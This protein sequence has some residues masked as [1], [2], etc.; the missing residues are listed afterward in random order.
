ML[1]IN[2]IKQT[3]QGYA[4]YSKE[5]KRLSRYYGSKQ[6]AAQRLAEIE[7]FASNEE[8]KPTRKERDPA[9]TAGIRRSAKAEI[10]KRLAE[11]EQ[12]IL[13]LIE[14]LPVRSI[15]INKTRYEFEVD[16][17]RFEQIS[18]EIKAIINRWLQ[19]AQPNKPIRWF[20]DSHLNQSYRNGTVEA[21]TRLQALVEAVSGE[22]VGD[23][24]SVERVLNSEPYR[25][26]IE[27]VFARVFEE[28]AGFADEAG[29]N[30]AR[31][32]AQ[33]MAAGNSPRSIAS[34][35]RKEF[36]GLKGYRALR[37]ARTEINKAH[38]DARM[39]QAKD[40]RDRVGV[41]TMI[42]HISALVPNTRATHASRHGKL[43]TIEE[44]QAWW[45]EGY[46]RINCLCSTLEIIFIDGEPIQQ[47][48]IERMRK[49]GQQYFAAN[50][51]KAA[52]VGI[53]A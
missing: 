3:K 51:K 33:G 46:N 38:T 9:G 53:T 32:L 34:A 6:E 52:K 21:A 47:D 45:S 18:E 49:R 29:T 8:V 12:E 42:M 20:F 31:V 1:A 48:L 23:A 30:L 15:T 36:R 27:L 19:T 4:V 26:R 44:Q 7:Y 50:P 24:L 5:G 2:V 43:Y 25:R 28:M 41:D 40:A 22:G 39:D 13:P 35:M 10:A 11:A 14:S 37:I 16:A 17:E